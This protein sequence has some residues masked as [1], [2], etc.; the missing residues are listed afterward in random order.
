M[1]LTKENTLMFKANIVILCFDTACSAVSF[2]VA[3]DTT[4][5][6]SLGRW[7]GPRSSLVNPNVGKSAAIFCHQ[8]TAWVPDMFCNFYVVKSHKIANNSAT[9]EAIEKISTDLKSLEI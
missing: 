1:G 9:T 4:I 3:T 5:S 8:V 6:C 2:A 7:F